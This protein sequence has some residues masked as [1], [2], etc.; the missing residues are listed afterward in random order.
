MTLR[1]GKS[2]LGLEFIP[3]H[4]FKATTGSSG[5]SQLALEPILS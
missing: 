1:E 5:L 2:Y 3:A 4:I